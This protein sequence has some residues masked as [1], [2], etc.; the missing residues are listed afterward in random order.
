MTQS[1][2]REERENTRI[3]LPVILASALI[4]S[5]S[6]YWVSS[7]WNGFSLNSLFINAV[8]IT[9]IT[10]FVS[11]LL[12]KVKKSLALRPGEILIVYIMLAIA[13]GAAGRDTVE[14]LTQV[15]GHPFWFASPENEWE[16]IFFNY[17]PRWLMVEDKNV[18]EGFYT[19][20]ESLYQPSVF[21]AWLRPLLFW[22]A[23]LVVLYF[24]MMCINIVFR[25]QWMERER[26]SFPV[27]Q[28]PLGLMDP[29]LS[30]YKNKTFWYG[31]GGA[32]WL[33]LMNGLHRLYPVIPGPTYGRFDVSA[34][35]TEKPWNAI[36]AV[37]IEFLPFILGLAFFIP[38]TLSFSIWFFYWFWKIE[39]VIGTVIGF[40]YLPGF[41]GYWMQG[42]GGV[43]FLSIMFFFWAREHL[44]HVLKTVFRPQSGHYTDEAPLYTFAILGVILSM[45]FLVSFCYYAGMAAWAAITFL[46]GFYVMSIVVTRMRA[47]LGPPTHRFPFSL[48]GFITNM[49]GTKRIDGATLTQFGMFKFV[50]F[51]HLSTPMPPMLEGLYMKHKLRVDQTGILL[52]AMVIA[53]IIGTA[54]GLIGNVQRGYKNISETWVGDWAFS[55][56]ARQLRYPSGTNYLYLIY[57]LIG[58]SIIAVLAVMSRRFVW[59]PFHPLGYIIAAEWMLRYLWFPIFIAWLVKWG[60]LKFGGLETHRKAVLLFV[61]ITVGDAVM[62]ALWMIYGLVFSKW[63]LGAFY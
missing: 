22:A 6:N 13:T 17:L 16:D 27:A 24:G 2:K 4:V 3:R 15:V 43:I 60:I 36:D 50:D 28:V 29:R 8:F 7:V 48:T 32:A 37:Y 51:G 33:S 23:F 38:V 53:I 9:F 18:L 34:L 25:K 52:S 45:V 11:F 41:P 56:V 31:F 30:I 49:L 61:G 39:M 63:T 55:D 21:R 35:F 46:G 57:T 47:E 12:G 40:R 26:L 5:V 62:I 59:W 44:W 10:G 58:G 19:Y 54:S 14:L 1:I 20:N 42:M